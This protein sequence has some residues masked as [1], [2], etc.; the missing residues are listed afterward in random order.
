MYGVVFGA[1]PELAVFGVFGSLESLDDLC[2]HDAGQV[3]VFAIRLLSSSPAWVAEDIDIGCPDGEAVEL[4]VFASIEH[5]LIVL[6]AELGAGGVEDA[7][8]EVGIEGCCHAHGLGEDGDVAHIGS[9]V[10]GFAPPEELLDAH[11]R[12]GRALV[13]HEHGFL[14]ER[15]A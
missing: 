8:E 7:V 4:L 14:V 6:G 11:A 13:E 5:A 10:E 3:W 12:Y 9:A 2:S 1:G 15:E